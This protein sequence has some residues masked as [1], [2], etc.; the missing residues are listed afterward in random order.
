MPPSAT[1]SRAKEADEMRIDLRQR[2]GRA[3]DVLFPKRR[4]AL[5]PALVARLLEDPL[6]VIDIGGAM[7][8]DARWEAIPREALRLMSFEPDARSKESC[9]ADGA[10]RLLLDIGLA[11]TAGAR[12][13][14]LTAGPFA[15]S[16]Y[17]ANE[18]ILRCFGVWPWY[19]PAGQATIMVDTLDSR[20]RLH[21]GWSADF[22]KVDVEGADLDVLKGGRDGLAT[23]FGVQVEVDFAGRNVGAPLQSDVDHWMRAAGFHPHLLFREHWVRANGVHGV[24]SQPQIAWADAVYFRDREW[25]IEWIARSD[26]AAEAERRLAAIS[27]IL[28]AYGAHDYAV[29]IIAAARDRGAVDPGFCEDA[30]RSVRASL[31][32]LLPFVTRGMTALVL[33]TLFAAPLALLGARGRAVGRDLIAAQAA[34]LFDGLARW[35]RRSGLG[36]CCLADG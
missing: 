34:P 28:L 32:T 33:S 21:P 25:A 1:A 9:A 27:A 35:A 6:C 14:H 23:A 11:D 18:E 15:S 8:P 20:L 7:G 3:L 22:V 16:L 29:E 31:V 24:F 5:A 12:T 4:L 36:G 30:A 2:L 26:G 13:L 10:R 17:A 19:E